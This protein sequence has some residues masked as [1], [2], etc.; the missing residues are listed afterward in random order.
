MIKGNGAGRFTEN[1]AAKTGN[2]VDP[3]YELMAKF[4][5]DPV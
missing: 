2:M 4:I 1:E 3:G 5:N